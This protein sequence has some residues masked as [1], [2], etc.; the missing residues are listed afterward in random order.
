[1]EI[2]SAAADKAYAEEFGMTPSQFLRLRALENQRAAIDGAS[3]GNINLNMIMG[4]N[5]QPM[6]NIGK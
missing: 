1:V 6:M 4:D 2:A 5:V 3:A